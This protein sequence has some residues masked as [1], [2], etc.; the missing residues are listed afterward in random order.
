MSHR[1]IGPLAALACLLVLPATAHAQQHEHHHH[2]HRQPAAQPEST[3]VDDA[4]L[5]AITDE[6]R[7]A[8]FPPL[9]RHMEHAPDFN[10][11]LRFNRLEGWRDEGETGLAWEAS[12]WAGSDVNR[13]WIRSEGERHVGETEAADL[14]LLYGRSISAWWDVVTGLRHDFRPGD[15][16]DWL[17]IGL[18]GLSPYKFEVQATAYFGESGQ[19]ALAFEAEYELRLTNRLILQPV[20]ELVLMGKDDP[21]RGVAS[22]FSTLEAGLRLRYEFVRQVAPYIGLHYERAMGDTARLRETA[23]DER[24]KTRVVAGLRIWF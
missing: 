8:A 18:Q 21:A 10:T 6:D 11:M 19:A 16:Q 1:N 23:G 2:H 9:T 13:L 12:G 4:D 5:P 14:E 24:A 3:R 7:A 20:V 15:S 17:A 22:G